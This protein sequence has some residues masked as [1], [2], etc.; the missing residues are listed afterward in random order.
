MAMQMDDKRM[1]HQI[2]KKRSELETP[3]KARRMAE[4][5]ERVGE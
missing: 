3:E 4:F 1:R 5:C 2:R